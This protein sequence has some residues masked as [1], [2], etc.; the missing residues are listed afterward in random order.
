MSGPGL[1]SLGAY[2]LDRRPLAIA[3]YR[4]LWIASVVGAVGG[5]FSVV[6]IP[7]QLYAVTGSSAAVGGSAAVSLAALIVAALWTGAAADARDRRTVLLAGYCGLALT[8]AGLWAQAAL[9]GRS[10]P[11]LLVLVACQGL[12]FGAVMTTMGAAV[13]RLVP[14]DLL[15]AA[16]SLSSLVRYAGS[17]LGPL[18]AGVLIPVVGLGSL[19]LLD[20][21]ALLA[22]LWA[23]VR[24]PPLPPR[25]SRVPP[26]PLGGSPFRR[27]LGGFRY[28]AASR[29][30]VAVVAVDLA[31]MVFGM[32]AALLPELAARTYG[33]TAGGGPVLGL[34][35]AAYPAGVFAVGLVSG[36]F[37]R[38]RRHGALLA[39]AAGAWGATVVVFGLA[40]RLWLAL[41]ALALGG[42]VNFVLSTFRNVITQALT[43]DALRGRIQG[44]LTV[45]TIGG[46]QVGNLLHGSAGSAFGPRAVIAAGGLLTAVTVAVIAR[47]VPELW[48]YTAPAGPPRTQD[49]S[50]ASVPTRPE[51]AGLGSGVGTPPPLE[52]LP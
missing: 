21:V 36:T 50:P 52:H 47:A 31:A 42:A 37:T 10:V 25:P 14:A 26:S 51:T 8:Y 46:P 38:V 20:S 41:T 2:T 11:V 19:Y 32:P 29:L 18:L 28:L 22:V 48:Q 45:V 33:G 5:S 49:R 39:A 6:A 9:G 23:V 40:S 15:P 1:R 16:T 12:S 3:A 17:I 43:D 24:L 30:L 7:A 44:S 13:P 35:Y 27:A 34:L 4:R